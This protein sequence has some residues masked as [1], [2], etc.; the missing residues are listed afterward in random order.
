MEE[1]QHHLYGACEASKGNFVGHNF[2]FIFWNRLEKWI[3]FT[4]TISKSL[5]S[6]QEALCVHRRYPE[7]SIFS[8]ILLLRCLC[9]LQIHPKKIL[10]RTNKACK[11]RR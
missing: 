7:F 8:E 10:A 1:S 4:G 9:K 2:W 5:W 6:Q 3:I 11:A